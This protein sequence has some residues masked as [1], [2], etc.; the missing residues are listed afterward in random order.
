ML[1]RSD[2]G[3]SE[4]SLNLEFWSADAFSRYTPGKARLIGRKRYY[5][6]LEKAVEL[7]GVGN[8]QSILVTGIESSEATL[9]A[10]RWLV[11][12]K[13]VPVLSPF[14]PILGAPLANMSAPQE[15]E[16]V[17]LYFAAREIAVSHD[18]YL[19]P[20]C[21]PC[22]CNTMSFPWDVPNQSL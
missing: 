7:F 18:F 1:F 21:V 8:V 22:Q 2:S 15:E 16:V 19:G 17:D 3:V 6:C 4:M 14:R 10:V 20:R 13:I 12:R 9:Q 5:E 11:E